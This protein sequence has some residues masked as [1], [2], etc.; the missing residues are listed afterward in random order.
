MIKTERLSITMSIVTLGLAFSV[1]VPL[2]LR[3]LYLVVLGSE[4][5]LRLSGAAQFTA[6]IVAIVCAGVEAIIRLHPQAALRPVTYTATFW[7]LPS[8]IAVVTLILLQQATWW[9]YQVIA[10]GAGCAL[11]GLVISLQ[12]NAIASPGHNGQSTSVGASRADVWQQPMARAGLNSIAYAT[13]LVLYITLYGT[14]ARSVLSATAVVA[15]SGLLALGLLR[16]ERI[17]IGR[18]WLYAGI[19]ALVMGELTWALNYVGLRAQV[20]GG[21]LMLTFYILSNLLQQY[22]VKRLNAKVLTEMGV[23]YAV[24]LVTLVAI[25]LVSMG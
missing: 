12:Y 15:I 20:G 11:I 3:E 25:S 13:V 14:R 6:I 4:L 19:I 9:G 8:I 23:V 7:A 17:R 5:T 22:L 21:F 1:L 2:P 24:G 10:L 16:D 18:T